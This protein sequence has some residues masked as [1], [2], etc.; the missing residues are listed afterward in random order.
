MFGDMIQELRSIVPAISLIGLLGGAIGYL[1][2]NI[3]LYFRPPIV[4]STFL[5]GPAKVVDGNTLVIK[6]QIVRLYGVDAPEYDQKCTN[7][8]G[9]E[10]PCGRVAVEN[11]N[12]LVALAH[13]HVRCREQGQASPRGV[14]AVCE[15]GGRNLNERMLAR[16]FAWAKAEQ[17]IKHYANIEQLARGYGRGVFQAE[18]APPWEYR[19][20]KEAE[21]EVD[22]TTSR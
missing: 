18:N 3:A 20:Q 14:E 7:V 21:R 10:W 17:G 12:E 4:A 8:E 5:S 19:A 1:A 6:G 15:A 16:G 22:S 2:S 9:Q 11:L 13:A